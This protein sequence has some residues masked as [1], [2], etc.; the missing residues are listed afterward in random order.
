MPQGLAFAKWGTKKQK[1]FFLPRK[2][3]NGEKS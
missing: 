1:F 2:R 3:Y